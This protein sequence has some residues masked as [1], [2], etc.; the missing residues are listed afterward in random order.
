MRAQRPRATRLTRALAAEA[1]VGRQAEALRGEDR[2]TSSPLIFWGSTVLSA[3]F[4]VAG[5]LTR[6][7]WLPVVGA[8]LAI[9]LAF[10]LGASPRFKIWAFSLPVLRA[11][12]A[13]VVRSSA[14]LA[15]L[16]VVPFVSFTVWLAAA[17]VH[18]NVGVG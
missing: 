4:S 10:Y 12:A 18:Q 8:I 7:P 14:L 9:P 11:I 16:I 15:T 3:G 1:R 13:G 5:V 6:K 17:V 2:C